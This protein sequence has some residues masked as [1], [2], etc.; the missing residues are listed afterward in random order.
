MGQAFVNS[1]ANNSIYGAYGTNL[2]GNA[3]DATPATGYTG[4]IEQI[5]NGVLGLN[6]SWAG[7]TQGIFDVLDRPEYIGQRLQRFFQQ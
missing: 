4:T 2:D 6:S 3:Y 1:S 5:V 7:D